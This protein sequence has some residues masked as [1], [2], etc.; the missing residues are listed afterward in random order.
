MSLVHLIRNEF[1]TPSYMTDAEG[2]IH[3]WSPAAEKF[4]GFS[5][6]EILGSSEYQLFYDTA[7]EISQ[8]GIRFSWRCRKDG[9]VLFV[10]EQ[11]VEISDPDDHDIRFMK[12]LT[13]YT[14]QFTPAEE[15]ELWVAH[16]AK[17][18]AGV[19]AF[20]LKSQL[21]SSLNES[22]AKNFGYTHDEIKGVSYSS[23]LTPESSTLSPRI[24]E[25]MGRDGWGV[26]NVTYRRKDNTTGLFKAE[27][28][29][30]WRDGRVVM[31]ACHT[32][33]EEWTSDIS[34]ALSKTATCVVNSAGKVHS[35]GPDAPMLYGYRGEELQDYS[36]LCEDSNKMEWTP[37]TRF[38]WRR[39]KDKSRLF[40]QETILPVV[41]DGIENQFLVYTKDL[42]NRL[43]DGA[44]NKMMTIHRGNVVGA[45]SLLTQ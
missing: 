13:D 16:Y 14:A 23:L 41:S 6:Q 40:V 44:K 24:L 43:S 2:I 30:V 12:V 29:P 5:E 33:N 32:T 25:I 37:Q 11:V 35:W 10:Q 27:V 34:K 8:G 20:D 38:G 19:A 28:V 31:S 9:E 45:H 7:E 26:F 39:R 36:L 3:V 18:R 22:F 21:F 15:C 4:F 42:T 17:R 1:D